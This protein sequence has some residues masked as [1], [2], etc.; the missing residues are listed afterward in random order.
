MSQDVLSELARQ[1]VIG[2][3]V[4]QLIDLRIVYVKRK[5]QET[6]HSPRQ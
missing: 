5:E 6:G 2:K 3:K 4:L 1:L